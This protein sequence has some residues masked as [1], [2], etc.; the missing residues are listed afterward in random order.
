MGELP[1]IWLYITKIMIKGF[2]LF[3][4]A[5]LHGHVT[6]RNGRFNMAEKR[7][8]HFFKLFNKDYQLMAGAAKILSVL[9][10]IKDASLHNFQHGLAAS[11][12][13]NEK[14]QIQHGR[15]CGCLYVWK[16]IILRSKGMKP[17]IC[18]FG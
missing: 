1:K 16:P 5:V 10:E 12:C 13:C 2:I 9:V 4:I 6:M 8:K 15:H 18:V 14:W 7:N 3:H 17:Q 11:P